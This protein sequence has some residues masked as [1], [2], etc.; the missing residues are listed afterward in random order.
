MRRP[1]GLCSWNRL[2]VRVRAFLG[3]TLRATVRPISG[4]G[5]GK[6][7]DVLR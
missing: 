6:R 4:L 7:V 3:Y 2:V 5:W 1:Q